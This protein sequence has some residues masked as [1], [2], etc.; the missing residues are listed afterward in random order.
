LIALVK[1]QFQVGPGKVGKGGVVRDE[2]ARRG[3]RDDVKAFLAAAGWRVSGLID[4]P[5]EGSDGNHEYLL[6]ATAPGARPS[7]GP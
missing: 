5:I 6:H 3:A 1:P 4:S 2:A 7:S